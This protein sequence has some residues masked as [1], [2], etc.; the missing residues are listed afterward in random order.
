MNFFFVS[1]KKKK[2]FFRNKSVVIFCVIS[3]CRF[4]RFIYAKIDNSELKTNFSL[5]FFILKKTIE[6][7][8]TTLIQFFVFK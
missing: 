6:K 1:H 7:V 2:I 8:T 4:G 3:V 5:N